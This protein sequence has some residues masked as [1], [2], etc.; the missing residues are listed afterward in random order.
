MTGWLKASYPKINQIQEFSQDQDSIYLTFSLQ[1][2]HSLSID[3]DRDD[4]LFTPTQLIK[5]PINIGRDQ[6]DL[7]I[8]FISEKLSGKLEKDSIE[9]DHEFLY[10]TFGSVWTEYNIEVNKTLH[11]YSITCEQTPWID[12]LISLHRSK[13]ASKNQ[14]LLIDL[15]AFLLLFVTLSGIWIGIQ[16][17]P[18]K[19]SLL[20]IAFLTLSCIALIL[21]LIN[22]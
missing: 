16:S 13:K 19:R 11:L 8:K 2:G 9:D 6:T 15:T 21:I 5:I 7:I 1:D 10:F 22:R 3:I 18:K 14:R 20:A 17:L 12:A 4:R